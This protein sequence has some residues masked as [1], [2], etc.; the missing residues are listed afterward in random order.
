MKCD[1]KIEKRPELDAFFIASYSVFGS[2]LA[3]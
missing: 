2:I 3:T 1:F